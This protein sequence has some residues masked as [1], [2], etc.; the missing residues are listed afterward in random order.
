MTTRADGARRKQFSSCDACR[1]SRIRCVRSGG[2]RSI[3]DRSCAHCTK[4]GFECT[5]DWLRA[6]Q[7]AN[8]SKRKSQPENDSSVVRAVS[9]E[10]QTLRRENETEVLSNP[11]LPVSSFDPASH[12]HHLHPTLWSLFSSI[13]EPVL[14]F[15]L[16]A[17][18]CPYGDTSKVSDFDSPYKG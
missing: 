8:Q 4:K 3:S 9:P 16:S 14:A 1:R 12:E 15:W 13:F 17:E 18:C 2:S 6:S 5:Y 10:T 11:P 7:L